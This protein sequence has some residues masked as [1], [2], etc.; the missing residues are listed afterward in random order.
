M[1]I[2]IIH[3][4][5]NHTRSSYQCQSNAMALHA[6]QPHC[7]VL[8]SL[9]VDALSRSRLQCMT[10]SCNDDSLHKVSNIKY[11]PLCLLA[12]SFSKPSAI[13]TVSKVQ[14]SNAITVAFLTFFLLICDSCCTSPI[15]W[16]VLIFS[17]FIT[18]MSEFIGCPKPYLGNSCK[19]EHFLRAS[20]KSCFTHLR[21]SCQPRF[22]HMLHL[23]LLKFLIPLKQLSLRASRR[24]SGTSII[25]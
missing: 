16:L 11:P 15:V 1:Y 5:G 24:C 7:L 9:N 18:A 25:Y 8:K 17:S 20:Q 12:N 3:K 2:Y 21:D 19:P 4:Q 10:I 14:A 22:S 6:S 13:P 23:Y